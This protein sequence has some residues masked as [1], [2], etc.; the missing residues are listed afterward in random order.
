MHSL[1]GNGA[2]QAV[3]PPMSLHR[4]AS[5]AID[6]SAADTP[7][8]RL[9]ARAAKAAVQMRGQSSVAIIVVAPAPV[10]VPESIRAGERVVAA[11]RPPDPPTGASPSEP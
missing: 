7:H 9:P 11:F 6:P 5:R 2:W 3:G 1:F 10:A 8:K 4:S